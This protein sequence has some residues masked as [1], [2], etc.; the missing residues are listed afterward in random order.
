MKAQ[1]FQAFFIW[2]SFGN[3]EFF[4]E[5]TTIPEFAEW[6]IA[7][8]YGIPSWATDQQGENR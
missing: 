8:L 7:I 4:F 6:T 1:H 3:H 5:V 2:E